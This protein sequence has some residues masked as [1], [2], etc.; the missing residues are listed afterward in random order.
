MKSEIDRI[1]IARENLTSA[2]I[3]FENELHRDAI[4]RAYYS[5]Y[6]HLVNKGLVEELYAKYIAKAYLLKE[7]KS[8]WRNC[9][10][11]NRRIYLNS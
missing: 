11:S 9:H 4:T 6:L 7:L 1:N 2:E 8:F 5:M 3:L 10:E